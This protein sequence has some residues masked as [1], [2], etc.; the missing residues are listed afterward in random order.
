MMHGPC[1]EDDPS[2]A[3]MVDRKC[4]KHFPNK[5]MQHSSVDSEGYPVYR[6]R[7]DKIYEEKSKHHLHNGF[8]IPYNATLLKHY[9]CH[10][11]VEMCNQ[12]GS[13]KYLLKYINKGP[14]RVSSELYEP[15]TTVD[16]EQ[17]Q[18]PVDKIK[19]Y[20]DF[21]YLSV[22]EVVWRLFGF[23]VQYRT[24]YVKRLSFHLPGE[25][26]VLYDK[27]S[28]LE[29]VLHKP[30]FGHSM[31]EGW[32]KMNELYPAARE[33]TYAELPTKEIDLVV[34][35]EEKKNVALFYIEELMRLRG[36]TLRR[37][38]EIPYPD[39]RCISEFGEE[40]VYLSCDS[41][42]KTELGSAID[43]AVFSPEFFNGLKFSGVPNHIL[44]LRVGE[45]IINGT[46]FGKKVIIPRLRITPSDKHLLIKIVRK[47]YPLSLSFAMTINKCQGQS[48]SKVG[49]YLP[50]PVFTHG[51]LYVA[52]S[53]F[54]SKRG[55]K[56]VVCDEEGNVSK[57]TTN[58]VYKEVLHGL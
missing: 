9:Q 25:Q 17:I 52:I 41:I 31:F 19:A 48:L 18:K 43:D 45:K 28:D 42:D 8:V 44:T 55:L 6:R 4:S 32:M 35:D 47:Q 3:C 39:E 33:L 34:S 20:L 27:N 50:R 38:P 24:P 56:V 26:Q 1:D 22:C 13:I 29:T 12:T 58:V 30:S 5:F 51:Q 46:H 2:Q 36:T 7:D 21:R 23:E 53:R 57:T 11:N 37:C 15:A 40:M 54:K 49:L 10:I 14:D 16:G